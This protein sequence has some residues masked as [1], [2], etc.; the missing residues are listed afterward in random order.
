[1]LQDR[2]AVWRRRLA[3][4][5]RDTVTI[6][7]TEPDD[8]A[9]FIHVVFDDDARWGAL[10]DNLHVRYTEQRSGVG[11]RLMREAASIVV[12]RRGANALYLWVLEQNVSGQSFYD[13]LGGTCVER[14]PLTPPGGDPS[15]MQGTP[16]KLRYAWDDAAVIARA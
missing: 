15:R 9:G 6:V 8:L 13:A 1:V 16:A 5:S 7:A 14:A 11:T 2:I 10:V 12:E 4:T 3:D